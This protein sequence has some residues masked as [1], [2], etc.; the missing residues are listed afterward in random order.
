MSSPVTRN[1]CTLAVVLA[2]VL[3][4][5]AAGCGSSGSSSTAAQDQA[6]AVAQVAGQIGA[7]GV[8]PIDPTLYASHEADATW[9]GQAVD[10][11]TFASTA[12]RDKWI[13]AASQFGPIL[14][15]GPLWAMTAG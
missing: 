13:A 2:T 7:T 8:Q 5:A 1:L 10:I 4:L 6:P 15:K 3:A 9:H 11:A 14:A 12:L